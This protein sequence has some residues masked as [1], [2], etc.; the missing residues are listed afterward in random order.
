M[1]MATETQP[2]SRHSKLWTLLM[3]A[4][5]VA[6]TFLSMLAGV[7][8]VW[9][10]FPFPLFIIAVLTGPLVWVVP[11]AA[12]L[13][14]SKQLLRGEPRVPYRSLLALAVLAGLSVWYFRTTWDDSVMRYGHD[15]VVA[16]AC[17]N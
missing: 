17:V 14:W 11:A 15:F 3:A 9:A 4:L 12:F 6:A 2:T 13:L 16:V 5:L 10:P 8:K 1:V 7:P